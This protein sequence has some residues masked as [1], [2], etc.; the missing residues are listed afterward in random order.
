MS[1]VLFDEPR[2]NN[3]ECST[4]LEIGIMALSQFNYA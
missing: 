4:F 2:N 3:G 1:K